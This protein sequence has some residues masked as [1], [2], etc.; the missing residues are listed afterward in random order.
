MLFWTERT[1]SCTI[2]D[3]INAILAMESVVLQLIKC[4]SWVKALSLPKFL[5]QYEFLPR[6]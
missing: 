1:I 4:F 6:Y 5:K 2:S 3:K